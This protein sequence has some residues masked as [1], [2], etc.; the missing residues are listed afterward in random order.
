MQFFDYIAVFYP[1]NEPSCP[2]ISRKIN[3]N[4]DCAPIF[5][6]RVGDIGP[7]MVQRSIQLKNPHQEGVVEI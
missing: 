4:A 2:I 1:V 3:M 5:K 6:F 7:I